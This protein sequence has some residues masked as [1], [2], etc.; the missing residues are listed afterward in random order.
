MTKVL[1]RC[2][3][4]ALLA[5]LMLTGCQL[6]FG[7][8]DDGPGGRPGGPRPPGSTC[9]SSEQCAAGCFCQGGV[10]EEGGF[11]SKDTDCPAG[12]SCDER[13]S[14]VPN[15]KPSCEKDADCLAGSVCDPNGQCS[16]TCVCESDAD[17]TKGGYDFCDEPRSTCMKFGESTCNGAVTC[18]NAK[19]VCP[20]GTV[21]MVSNG[22]WADVDLNGQPDCGAIASCDITPTCQAY[23]H[24]NDCK[25]G[26]GCT[27]VKKGINCTSETGGGS[28]QDGQPGCICAMYVY[29][30]CR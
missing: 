27:I 7:N 26:A 8:E 13:S 9:Q 12:Y 18:T 4:L 20:E 17:A 30:S 2:F 19:P 10:C 11:C 16:T 22:C 25:T 21:P 5:A 15:G 29:D 24:E 14:C 28:C 1:H 3:G 6:Y 23:Q